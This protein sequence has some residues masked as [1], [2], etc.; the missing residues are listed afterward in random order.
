M[1]MSFL[2]I[3][4]A[5]MFLKISGMGFIFNKKSYLRDS[6]NILDFVIVVSAYIP[7]I[8]KDSDQNTSLT[9]LRSLRILRPL[10]TIA[11]SKDLR[12]IMMAL[13]SAVPML[14]NTIFILIFFFLIF[15]IAGLQL[16]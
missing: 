6:W 3:Y 13:I 2:Y 12:V 9:G 15:A 11:K 5:E 14:L 10:K 1:E 7:I 8:I 16:F 4:T